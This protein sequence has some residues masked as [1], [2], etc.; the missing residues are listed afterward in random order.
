[1][2]QLKQGEDDDGRE[3]PARPRR[4]QRPFTG[5]CWNCRRT[6]HIS[7]NCPDPPPQQQS[8]SQQQPGKLDSSSTT[9][10]VSGG[11]NPHGPTAYTHFP[12]HRRLS[13]ARITQ[14]YTGHIVARYR[15][16][17]HS[18][19]TR[20]L[21]PDCYLHLGTE[22]MAW[23]TT[24]ECWGHTSHYSRAC[25]PYTSSGGLEHEHGDGSCKSPYFRSHPGY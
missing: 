18:V 21:E 22:T 2:E 7:R 1:M 14:R 19:E 13:P 24:G 17:I 23:T 15:G 20:R 8:G 11:G 5:V 4:G 16:C 9:D 10:H 12:C 3:G 6:G 25:T